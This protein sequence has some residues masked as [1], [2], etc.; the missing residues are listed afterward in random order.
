[1]CP[2]AKIIAVTKV[3][4]L[5][6]QRFSS[7]PKPISTLVQGCHKVWNLLFEHLDTIIRTTVSS[8][9]PPQPWRESRRAVPRR[10]PNLLDPRLSGKI[11]GSDA[12]RWYFSEYYGKS[13]YL[14]GMGAEFGCLGLDI[15]R[16]VVARV[17]TSPVSTVPGGR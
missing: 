15:R 1:V 5:L 17:R 3:S 2:F 11:S 16:S 12:G 10:F 9:Y 4:S 7:A 13:V 6:L 8:S 14:G